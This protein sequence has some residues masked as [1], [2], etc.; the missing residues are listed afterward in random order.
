MLP[1]QGLAAQARPETTDPLGIERLYHLKKNMH[2]FQY[3]DITQIWSAESKRLAS[4]RTYG[5]IRTA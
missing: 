3:S 4:K 2:Y 1:N 5:L